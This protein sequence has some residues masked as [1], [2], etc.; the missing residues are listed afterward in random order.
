MSKSDKKLAVKLYTAVLKASAIA[1]AN[2]PPLK[3]VEAP[4]FESAVA[5]V[6]RIAKLLA[7]ISAE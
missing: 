5:D 4:T 7:K 6:E 1:N 2:K 3:N